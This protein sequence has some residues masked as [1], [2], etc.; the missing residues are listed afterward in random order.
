[1]SPDNMEYMKNLIFQDRDLREEERL[2]YTI[3]YVP[4]PLGKGER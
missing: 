4:V 1:M 2:A 3:E